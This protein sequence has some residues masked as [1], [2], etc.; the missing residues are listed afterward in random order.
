MT[1][2]FCN[3]SP[4]WLYYVQLIDPFYLKTAG[5]LSTR[6][7]IF[8]CTTRWG[9]RSVWESQLCTRW[10]QEGSADAPMPQIFPVGQQWKQTRYIL[11]GSTSDSIRLVSH[12]DTLFR[13]FGFSSRGGEINNNQAFTLFET[14]KPVD[15][16]AALTLSCPCSYISIETDWLQNNKAIP[17]IILNYSLILISKKFTAPIEKHWSGTCLL[18]GAVPDCG[19]PISA[20]RLR[21]GEHRRCCWGWVD[22]KW[23]EDALPVNQ[24][25]CRSPPT[26]PAEDVC[27]PLS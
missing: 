5:K 21:G 8:I 9:K 3:R 17:L 19:T 4:V 6:S 20:P 23:H 24:Q 10:P 22:G 15:I 12:P 14:R 25:G 27:H 1:R 2:P 7:V 11:S 16:R 18:S 26:N 13:I